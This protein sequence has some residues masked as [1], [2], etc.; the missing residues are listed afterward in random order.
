MDALLQ[1][2]N[3]TKRFPGVVALD[4]VSLT[5]E[6]GKVHALVGEN[7]AGKSTLVRILT[8]VHSPDAGQL[9]WKG[10]AFSRFTPEQVRELGIGVIYQESSLVPTLSVG[11]NVFLGHLPGRAPGFVDWGHIQKGAR[12]LLTQLGTE[13]SPRARVNQLNTIDQRMVEV[14]RSLSTRSDLLIMD[15]PTAALGAHEISILFNT[16]RKLRDRG[17]AVLYI[18]HFLEEVFRVSDCITVLRDGRLV[19]T[20]STADVTAEDIVYMMAGR[21][22]DA[23]SGGK[24]NVRDEVVLRVENL[25]RHNAF[26][27]VSFEL[28]AGEVLGLSGPVNSGRQALARALFGIQPADSGQ[29]RVRERVLGRATPQQAMRLGLGLIPRERHKEGLIVDA[30]LTRNI[31]LPSLDRLARAGIM[32]AA[33]EK[34][35]ARE[36]IE[37]LGIKAKSAQ[38]LVRYLSGGNQQKVVLSKWLAIA[39]HILILDE[40]TQGVD[41]A[42]KEEIYHLITELAGQGIG[43]L[44][45]SSEPGELARLCQ[46]V[47]VMRRGQLVA[48]LG[49]ANL[50]SERIVQYVTG[51][52]AAQ[53]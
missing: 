38:Q 18:S 42:S 5:L 2:N 17:V 39:P 40:P 26:Y 51:A 3:V 48:E 15:E 7:G 11:E 19:N 4:D 41:V 33:R 44:F 29:V 49:G 34:Q 52:G 9:V 25:T 35:L 30:S 23:A 28:R 36:Y 37:R 16:I 20:V 12:E 14:A 46:R 31:A 43:I 45:I 10:K 13:V 32:Q 1:V 50:T 47:L 24:S 27:S 21:R 53:A 6:P 22:L 8:G